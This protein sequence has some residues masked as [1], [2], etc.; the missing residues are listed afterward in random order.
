MIY[1][2][3]TIP[4]PASASPLPTVLYATLDYSQQIEWYTNINTSP[5]HIPLNDRDLNYPLSNLQLYHAK[6]PANTIDV[7]DRTYI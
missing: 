1:I 3:S 5:L 6:L 4:L 7:S 2:S